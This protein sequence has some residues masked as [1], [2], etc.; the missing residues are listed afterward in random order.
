MK[1]NKEL[2]GWL[3]AAI[4]LT[5]FVITAKSELAHAIKTTA[6]I[7]ALWLIWY[8][9]YAKETRPILRNFWKWT[10]IVASLLGCYSIFHRLLNIAYPCQ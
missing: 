1:A 10:F 6:D 2:V 9:W 4:T 3:G 8:G 7:I 5:C